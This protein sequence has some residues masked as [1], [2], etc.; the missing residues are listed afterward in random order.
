MGDRPLVFFARLGHIPIGLR[1]GLADSAPPCPIDEL[2]KRDADDV[3]SIGP[4]TVSDKLIENC[5]L[6]V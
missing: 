2:M 4:D 1:N 6:V 3:G 5:D